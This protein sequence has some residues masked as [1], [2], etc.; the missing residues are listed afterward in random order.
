M[1]YLHVQNFFLWKIKSMKENIK[2]QL[3]LEFAIFCNFS[4][5][6]LTIISESL[7]IKKFNK[8]KN[9]LQQDMTKILQTI[10]NLLRAFSN[11]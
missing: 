9:G 8:E 11:L 7:T 4:L 3:K 1:K 6:T 2:N 5:S 10:Q